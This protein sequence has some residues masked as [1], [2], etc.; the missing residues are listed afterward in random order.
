MKFEQYIKEKSTIQYEDRGKTS[1]IKGP[2][3]P[4]D[5][6]PWNLLVIGAHD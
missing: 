1:K 2:R 5:P 6:G 4:R 3:I